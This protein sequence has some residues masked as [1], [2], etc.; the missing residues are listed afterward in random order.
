[1]SLFVPYNSKII[2]S[3]MSR[4]VVLSWSPHLYVLLILCPEVLTPLKSLQKENFVPKL[5]LTRKFK[6]L[7][8][9]QNNF[10]ETFRYILQTAE[11]IITLKERFFNVQSNKLKEPFEA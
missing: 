4:F 8:L 2:K 1:M 7:K 6:C 9:I 10:F 5:P 3:R 11:I